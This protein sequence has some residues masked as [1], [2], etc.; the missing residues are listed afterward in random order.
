MM[1]TVGYR[2]SRMTTCGD[3]LELSVNSNAMHVIIK[4]PWMQ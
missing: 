3:V 2:M 1:G 4:L